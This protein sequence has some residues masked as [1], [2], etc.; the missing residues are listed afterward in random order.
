MADVNSTGII[1]PSITN[2]AAF[3]AVGST[4]FLH[5]L[6]TNAQKGTIAYR[7][8]WIEEDKKCREGITINGLYIPGIYYFYLNFY[9]IL[10]KDK[11]TGRKKRILPLFTDV[12]LEFFLHV[13]LARKLGKGVILVKPRRTG[14]S[15][16]NS[17]LVVYEYNFFRD[18]KCIVSAFMSA[19]SSNTMNMALE[20]LNFLDNNTEWRKQRDPN[21][22]DFVK[23]RYKKTEDGIE[24]W[25]GTMSEIQSITFKDNPFAAIGLSSSVFIMDE[26]GKWPNLI[27]SYNISEPCWKD[28][29]DTTGIPIILGTGGDMEGGTADFSEMFYNPSKYNLLSFENI[30]DGDKSSKS[31]IGYFIP[32]TKMRFGT[33]KDEFKKNPTLKGNAMVD[34]NGN[35]NQELA[36][37]SIEDMRTRV[38]MGNDRKAIRD[39]TTQY[40]LTPAEAFLR[41]KGNIFPG[42]L[43]NER[44]TELESNTVY[45]DSEYVVELI[46]DHDTGVISPK[47]SK[48]LQPIHNFPLKSDDKQEGCLVVYEH[49]VP[50]AGGSIP[51]GRYIASCDPYD[52]DSSTTSSLGSTLIYNRLTKKIVAEYTARPS[53]AKLYYAKV[54]LLLKYYNA[55]MLYENERK[56]IF[57]YFESVNALYY[58]AEQPAVIKDAVPNSK[59]TRGYGIHMSK[60]IKNYGEQLV[61][62]WLVENAEDP[63]NPEHLNLHKLRCIPLIKELI[64]YSPDGNYDRAMALLVLMWYIAEVR[65][66]EVES[67]DEHRA[68]K[69]FAN[70]RFFNPQNRKKR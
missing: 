44:L 29:E 33:Y 13:E 11:V 18:A 67:Y 66:I 35:S 25:R 10:A 38:A 15:F 36:L 12:D 27:T 62:S 26:A 57:D 52:Q 4:F 8:F 6:Y 19:F 63:D 7:D 28:G 9:P 49:P 69:T 59:V 51:S 60:P 17:C 70:S 56:G 41:S 20:G 64:A 2:A 34:E 5:G 32:A 55:Q 30:W 21:R 43:L 48:S 42:V 39:S 24:S 54:L 65:H 50:N 37:K 22:R 23:A 47:Q 46:M 14:F 58:L 68:I 31:S 3:Q 53:T 40:P 16:K 1:I 61:L 45:K